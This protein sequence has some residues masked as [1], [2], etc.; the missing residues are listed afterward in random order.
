MKNAT[1]QRPSYNDPMM[2]DHFKKCAAHGNVI[3]KCKLCDL[4]ETHNEE[5]DV[6]NKQITVLNAEVES[7]KKE[8]QIFRESMTEAGRNIMTKSEK[9]K[10]IVKWARDNYTDALQHHLGLGYNLAGLIA[11]SKEWEKANPDDGVGGI[12]ANPYTPQIDLKTG[13]LTRLIKDA[14][15]AK[16]LLE[17]VEDTFLGMI[18]DKPSES[19]KSIA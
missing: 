13:I 2:P 8:R 19:N 18:D 1:N 16:G 3:G 15:D 9:A 11:S 10:V 4:N 7:L 5:V 17:F 6:L 12:S 14:E